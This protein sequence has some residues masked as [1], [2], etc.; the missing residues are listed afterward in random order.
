GMDRG[1]DYTS[2]V[3]FLNTADINVICME[4]SG[5]RIYNMFGSKNNIFYVPHLEDA[6]KLAS[7]ITPQGMSCVMSPASAS[8]GI[9]KNFEERGDVFK[10]LVNNI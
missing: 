7:E 4:A 1:I 10:S 8:Y 3:D 2:L 6:V 5:K 9:F